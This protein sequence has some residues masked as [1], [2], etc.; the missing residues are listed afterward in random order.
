MASP[1]DDQVVQLYP[2][3]LAYATHLTGDAQTGRD[4]LHSSIEHVLRRSRKGVHIEHLR[5]Y[6]NKAIVNEY[7]SRVRKLNVPI[8]DGPQPIDPIGTANLRID[9]QDALRLLTN[10]QR[11]AIVTRYYLDLSERQTAEIMRCS[12]GTVKALCSRGL[13]VIREGCAELAPSSKEVIR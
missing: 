12:V 5:A 1:V 9:L 13:Q 10:R 4:I 11:V 3:A 6:L 7:L 2:A 8:P